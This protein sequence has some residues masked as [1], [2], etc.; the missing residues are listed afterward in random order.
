[1]AAV[2]RMTAVGSARVNESKAVW[3]PAANRPQPANCDPP[4]AKQTLATETRTAAM[5]PKP[6]I[7]Q[8][9]LPARSGQSH[10]TDVINTA[11]EI[12]RMGHDRAYARK[13]LHQYSANLTRLLQG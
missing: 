7:D 9:H 13:H 6:D 1:M 2:T 12:S 10:S 8:R 4:A 5:G 11:E 3:Y